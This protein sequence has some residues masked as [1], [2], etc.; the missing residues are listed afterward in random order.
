MITSSLKLV[1]TY[2][3]THFPKR[4]RFISSL[5][6]S[7]TPHIRSLSQD[8]GP[9]QRKK[10]SFLDRI[11]SNSWDSHMHVL[12]P[13]NYP[14]ASEALYT[15]SPHTLTDAIRFEK[16]LNLRNIVL[17]QP[18][19]YGF[20][21]SCMLD[22]LRTLG[23]RRGRAVVAFDP[24]TILEPTLREWH[25]IGVRGVRINLQ[26]VGKSLSME[27]LKRTLKEHADIIRPFGW[28]L[29]LYVPLAMAVDLESI[30]PSLDVKVCLDH[31][32]HPSLKDRTTLYAQ[33]GD[34]Y[35]IPG[36][37]SMVNLLLQG[38][39]YVKISAPYRLGPK[40]AQR[41]LEP[42]AKELMRVAGR[43]RLVFASDWPHTRFEGLDIKP[44]VEKVMEWCEWDDG[45][46]DR[47]FRANADD[48][49]DVRR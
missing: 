3:V 4:F 48:L 20:D 39:T 27:E 25:A 17:V 7:R 46:I 47:I 44:F 23:S 8:H 13:Q 28:V 35:H 31:F 24:D 38:N 36:F 1:A 22:A 26:S 5:S 19:I 33:S 14:L 41:D 21:N 30:V 11:P 6:W 16:T 32:G 40:Q 34:P 2:I 49:W 10:S 9:S 18:S 12:D 29:Q 37:R 45:M 42:I 15:P 43:S